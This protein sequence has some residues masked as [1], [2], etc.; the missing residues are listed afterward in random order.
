M[1]VTL[2]GATGRAG[3]RILQELLRRSHSVRAVRRDEGRSTHGA[4]SSSEQVEWVVDDLSSAEKTTE[5]VRG[6]DAVISAYAPPPDNMD[7]LAAATLLVAEAVR[8]GGVSRLLV[9]GGAG[10]LQ[11]APGVTLLDSGNLPPEWRPIAIAH[12][13]TLTALQ[14]TSIDWTYVAPAAFFD[15]GERTG[16]YRVDTDHLV[17]DAG[18]QSRIS[19]EDYAIAMVDELEKPAHTRMRF[20]VGW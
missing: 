11:V 5:V 18:G 13:K 3:S 1:Q 4:A 16:R 7:A 19:M 10:G 15:P 6:S 9:V 17:V 2:I 14:S 12:G 8:N 20:A